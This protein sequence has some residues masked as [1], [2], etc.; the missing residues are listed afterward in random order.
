MRE[1]RRRS[2]WGRTG[3]VPGAYLAAAALV[4]LVLARWVWSGVVHLYFSSIVVLPA[5]GAARPPDFGALFFRA[6]GLAT[7]LAALVLFLVL[8]AALAAY[9]LWAGDV[10]RGA[11]APFRPRRPPGA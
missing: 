3:P 8:L 5:Y 1:I 11:K 9:A 2:A 10:L 7:S 6:L 4:G